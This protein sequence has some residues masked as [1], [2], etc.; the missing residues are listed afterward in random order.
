M[1]VRNSG[2]AL[3]AP[4]PLDPGQEIQLVQ[5]WLRLAEGHPAAI[6]GDAGPDRN[7]PVPDRDVG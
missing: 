2:V 5:Y 6:R 1:N 3:K 4:S 7:A